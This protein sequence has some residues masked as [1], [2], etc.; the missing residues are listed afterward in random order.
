[1]TLFLLSSVAILHS[2]PQRQHKYYKCSTFIFIS[3]AIIS[4]SFCILSFVKDEISLI[5]DFRK[6]SVFDD[7][8]CIIIIIIANFV[9]ISVFFCPGR[10]ERAWFP[11]SNALQFC[12]ALCFAIAMNRHLYISMAL[13]E[14]SI[15]GVWDTDTSSLLINMKIYYFQ[16]VCQRN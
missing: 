14:F 3:F 16:I 6:R 12:F 13:F 11:S 8:Y 4:V 5:L 7:A 10:F 9:L 15:A 1:M 2:K